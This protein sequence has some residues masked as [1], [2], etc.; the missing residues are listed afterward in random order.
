MFI[1]HKMSGLDGTDLYLSKFVAEKNPLTFFKF[2]SQ[3]LPNNIILLLLLSQM[4]T[5]ILSY[6]SQPLMLC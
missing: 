4:K 6:I 3:S 2:E 1:S 5:Q